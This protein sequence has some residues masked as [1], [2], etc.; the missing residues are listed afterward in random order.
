MKRTFAFLIL[1]L[2]VLTFMLV[3]CD[4][5]DTTT[6]PTVTYSITYELNGG[7][8]SLDNPSTYK[9]GDTVNLGFPTK[10]GYMFAGWYTDSAF[11]TDIVEIKDIKE[12]LTLYA[13]WA[14]YEDPIWNTPFCI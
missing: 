7:E 11:T 2:C 6:N 4:G 12:D 9:T 10:E 1:T 3:S 14:S 8:N 13:R 5:S